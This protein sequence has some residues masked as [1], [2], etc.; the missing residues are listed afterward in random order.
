[1]EKLNDLRYIIGLFFAAVGTVL[2]LLPLSMTDTRAFATQ[3]N[4]FSGGAMLALAI[5]LFWLRGKDK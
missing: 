1:M 4:L 2:I 5:F 3:L